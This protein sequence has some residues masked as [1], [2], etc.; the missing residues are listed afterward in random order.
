M[1]WLVEL[2]RDVRLEDMRNFDRNGFLFSIFVDHFRDDMTDYFFKSHHLNVAEGKDDAVLK[3]MNIAILVRGVL[4]IFGERDFMY[5]DRLRLWSADPQEPVAE[6]SAKSFLS[7]MSMPYE[8]VSVKNLAVLS[9]DGGYI[10]NET[11]DFCALCVLDEKIRNIALTVGYLGVNWVSLYAIKDHLG[12]GEREFLE[13]YE[14]DPSDLK[15]FT[16]MANNFKALGPAARHGEKGWDA[17]KKV[18]SLEG[19][20]S[21]ILRAVRREA[22]ILVQ[23]QK[24][25]DQLR[26]IYSPC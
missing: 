3:A 9:G 4:R 1:D 10:S 16:G 5:G 20:S 19:A 21:L 15:A 23:E 26:E 24:I 8:A 7:S 2:P 12:F 13:R 22:A 18:M 17:P 25:R 14:V 11:S 6:F